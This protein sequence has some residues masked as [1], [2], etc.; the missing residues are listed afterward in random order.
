MI[1]PPR[2][3]SGI[4]NYASIL[5][6]VLR[7]SQLQINIL[8]PLREEPDSSNQVRDEG[9]IWQVWNTIQ[10]L[11]NYHSRLSVALQI[12]KDLPSKELIMQWFAEPVRVLLC[13]SDVFLANN[14]GY[15]V[16]SKAHQRLLNSFMKVRPTTF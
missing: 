3:T 6:S 5:N 2:R 13:S 14:K 9:S 16:L 4:H 8:L 12:P 10:T 11:T 7:D 1:P 15:P